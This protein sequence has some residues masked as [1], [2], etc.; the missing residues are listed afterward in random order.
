MM[1]Q[2]CIDVRDTQPANWSVDGLI[3]L[4]NSRLEGI[5]S[6]GEAP[7]PL[8]GPD[9]SAIDS[10]AHVSPNHSWVAFVEGKQA[11]DRIGQDETL[12][13]LD[14]D[15]KV[16]NSI[17]W[18]RNWDVISGWVDN[19]HVSVIASDLPAGSAVL[20]N[21]FSGGKEELIATFPHLYDE[22]P[23][24]QWEDSAVAIY[25]PART[26]VVYLR[27]SSS[28]DGI[29]VV[30]WDPARSQALWQLDDT[31]VTS[32]TPKW[33]PDGMSLA[34]AGSARHALYRFELMIIDRDGHLTMATDFASSYQAAL[35]NG[36]SW[37]PR[38]QQIGLW[39]EARNAADDLTGA[40]TLW[41]L[42]L[43]EGVLTD[44]CVPGSVLG[45]ADPPRWSPD[46]QWLLLHN[47]YSPN[48]SR[49]IMVDLVNNSAAQIATDLRPV[50]WLTNSP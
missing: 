32:V 11:V 25:D 30:L 41:L 18:E 40:E 49:V 7:R 10:Y 6:F 15:G 34:V 35:I 16:V 46:G 22:Y 1:R 23:P 24:A 26:R 13:L 33:S 2:E 28:E 19:E 8:M 3:V 4:G 48:A 43:E 27:D 50:G 44:T 9:E 29:G 38:G 39:V 5:T 36:L 47:I 21:P 42:D 37:S 45:A 20:V 14:Q 17:A 12:V 31:S